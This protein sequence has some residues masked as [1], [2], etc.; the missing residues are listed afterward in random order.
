MTFCVDSPL[1]HLSWPIVVFEWTS[2][3]ATVTSKLPVVPGSPTCVTVTWPV[4][5]FSIVSARATENLR[6]RG[7]HRLLCAENL[8]GARD[9]ARVECDAARY[10][11]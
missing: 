5:S 6:R 1:W 3:P 8:G 11:L 9:A 2:L 10:F 7:D 4:N